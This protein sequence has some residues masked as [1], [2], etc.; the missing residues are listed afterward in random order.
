MKLHLRILQIKQYFK[1]HDWL[2]F[3]EHYYNNRSCVDSSVLRS[4]IKNDSISHKMINPFARSQFYFVINLI[5]LANKFPSSLRILKEFE[6]HSKNL[7]AVLDN[8]I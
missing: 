6:L 2:R 5:N 1:L 3:E 8:K 4:T 7:E